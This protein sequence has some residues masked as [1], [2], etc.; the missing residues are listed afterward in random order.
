MATAS[1][2]PSLVDPSTEVRSPVSSRQRLL[3][4]LAY[5]I[6][7]LSLIGL[8]MLLDRHLNVVWDRLTAGS[9]LAY[10]VAFVLTDYLKIHP[11]AVT[12]LLVW[13]LDRRLPVSFASMAAWVMLSQGCVSSLIKALTGRVRPCDCNWETVFTGLSIQGNHSFPSGHATGAF[14][15]A[16]F[17]TAYYPRWRWAFILFAVL[18]ALARVQLDRHFFSDVVA[19]GIL[20]WYWA[21]WIMA[22]RRR[23]AHNRKRSVAAPRRGRWRMLLWPGGPETA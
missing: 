21:V 13:R 11:V 1:H 20:G 19:G 12:L 7:W 14:A 3:R 15:L 23:A 8:V 2:A 4:P 18:T 6:L 17:L 5:A 10:F 16:A 9:E 22:W